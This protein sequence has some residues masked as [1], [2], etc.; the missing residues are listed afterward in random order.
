MPSNVVA[1]TS[2][3]GDLA[4]SEMG[5]TESMGT[6]QASAGSAYR[7]VIDGNLLSDPT[8]AILKALIEVL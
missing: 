1:S 2:F 7:Q 3:G 6:Y 4:H 5:G 8:H